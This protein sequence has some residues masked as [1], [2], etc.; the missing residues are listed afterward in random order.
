MSFFFAVLTKK[1]LHCGEIHIAIQFTFLTI[2]QVLSASL[3]KEG[4]NSLKQQLFLL[5]TLQCHF[6][7][8]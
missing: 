4:T 1:K 7:L 2:F 3:C 5:L 8:H 6:L